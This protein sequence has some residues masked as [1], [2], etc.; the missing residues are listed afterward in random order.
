MHLAQPSARPSPTLL[1]AVLRPETDEG[2]GCHVMEY[3]GLSVVECGCA[4][5]IGPELVFQ[6]R[7][8]GLG[9]LHQARCRRSNVRVH[10]LLRTR[11]HL[12]VDHTRASSRNGNRRYRLVHVQLR[13][14]VLAVRLNSAVKLQVLDF[15]PA[16]PQ[17]E[18]WAPP[19]S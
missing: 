4:D 2:C 6:R 16:N 8:N 17:N 18:T 13:E 11:E 10:D 9:E 15:E 3:L 14:A 12:G 5:L 19:P 7:A 1:F